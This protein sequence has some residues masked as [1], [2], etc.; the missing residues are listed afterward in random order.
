MILGG[1]DVYRLMVAV[2]MSR[3]ILPISRSLDPTPSW[4]PSLPKP[5]QPP[6]CGGKKGRRGREGHII[7]CPHDRRVA[8]RDRRE[9]VVQHGGVARRGGCP[10]DPARRRGWCEQK[11][12]HACVRVHPGATGP[13]KIKGILVHDVCMKR[14]ASLGKAASFWACV[15]ERERWCRGGDAGGRWG[16]GVLVGISR[17]RR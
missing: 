16:D 9:G 7:L 6:R 3:K 13:W 17:A 5:L 12:S 11:T 2:M 15:G 1:S 4:S 10:L 14:E 8:S